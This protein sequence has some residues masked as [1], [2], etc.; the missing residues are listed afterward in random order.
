MDRKIAPN[1]SG[2]KAHHGL[3]RG[4]GLL[5]VATL[6]RMGEVFSGSICAKGS[7]GTEDKREVFS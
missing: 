6:E 3:Y 7:F 1:V 5:R 4:Q 2:S